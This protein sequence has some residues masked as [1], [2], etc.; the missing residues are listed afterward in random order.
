MLL[1]AFTDEL[2]KTAAPA[3]RKTAGILAPRPDRLLERLAVTGALS[4]GALHGASKV[5]STLT[6]NPYDAPQGSMLGAAAKGVGGGL[7]AGVLLKALGKMHGA[8]RRR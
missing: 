3:L 7:L 2:V 8:K 4:S 5:K 6:G 1:E